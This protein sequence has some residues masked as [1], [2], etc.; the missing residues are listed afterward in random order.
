MLVIH[1]YGIKAQYEI[2]VQIVQGR[3]AQVTVYDL[4]LSCP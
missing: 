4:P 3:S 2:P 1:N